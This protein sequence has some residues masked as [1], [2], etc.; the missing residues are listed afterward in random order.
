MPNNNFETVV[1]P[2]IAKAVVEA[3][4]LVVSTSNIGTPERLFTPNTLAPLAEIVVVA[5]RVVAPVT[6]NVLERV[7]LER[8]VAPVTPSVPPIETLLPTVV[9]AMTIPAVAKVVTSVA[10]AT[11]RINF[12][13]IIFISL[14]I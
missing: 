5:E 1:P 14:L 9:A 7:A 3:R 8:V 12:D 13:F 6:A 2:P 4:E 10:I 11:C